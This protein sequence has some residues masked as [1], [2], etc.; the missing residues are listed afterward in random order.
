MRP[1]VTPI[2]IVA[3]QPGRPGSC[4]TGWHHLLRVSSTP[5]PQGDVSDKDALH[6]ARAVMAGTPP[7][8]ASRRYAAPTDR[9]HRRTQGEAPPLSKPDIGPR[10]RAATFALTTLLCLIG[11]GCGSAQTGEPGES[12]SPA[13]AT[14][15]GSWPVASGVNVDL[16]VITATEK[17]QSEVV[18]TMP[19]AG[20]V[21]LEDFTRKA[22]TLL[23]DAWT[24]AHPGDEVEVCVEVTRMAGGRLDGDTTGARLVPQAGG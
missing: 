9:Q 13:T 17:A 15:C 23:G 10:R 12:K 20:D 16:I 3:L 4:L 5:T 21:P 18:K 6:Q 22:M 1:M 8:P 19:E 14:G 24:D 7:S 2:S 11:G